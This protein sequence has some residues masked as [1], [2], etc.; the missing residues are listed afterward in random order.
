MVLKMKKLKILG[1]ALSFCFILFLCQTMP[2]FSKTE[3]LKAKLPVLTTSAGQ[4]PDVTTVNIVLEEAG[5]KYDYCDVPTVPALAFM[6]RFIPIL[7][8]SLKALPIKQ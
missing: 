7:K 8:S 6:L 4:S 3:T 1:L 2:G 5:I